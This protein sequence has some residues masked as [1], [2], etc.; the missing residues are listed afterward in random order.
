MSSA[1]DQRGRS[2]REICGDRQSRA[3]RVV[4]PMSRKIR[5]TRGPPLLVVPKSSLLSLDLGHP[6]PQILVTN[7]RDLVL[8]ESPEVP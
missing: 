8:S 5:G 3:R 1:G 4:V 2:A 6:A 7:E